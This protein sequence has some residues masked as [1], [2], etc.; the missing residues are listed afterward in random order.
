MSSTPV[1]QPPIDALSA[2]ILQ[3]ALEF[4]GLFWRRPFDF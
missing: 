1:V 2:N 3:K 4:Q